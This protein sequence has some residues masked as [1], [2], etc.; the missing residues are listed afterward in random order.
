MF[1]KK[2][3]LTLLVFGLIMT[4]GI[5]ATY[6]FSGKMGW[7]PKDNPEQ[8][9][10]MLEIMESGDYEAWLELM[11]DSPMADKVTQENFDQFVAMHQAMQDGDF[12]TAKQIREE[13]GLPGLRGMGG[14]GGGEHDPLMQEFRQN[15]GKLFDTNGDGVCDIGDIEEE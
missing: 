14:I 2:T 10:A 4:A 1:H 6:A 9:Q 15:G 7:G 13:L 12:E 3:L 8:H 11:G 5:G